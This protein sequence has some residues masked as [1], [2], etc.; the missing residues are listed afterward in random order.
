MP[1]CSRN[2]GSSPGSPGSRT[3][4]CCSARSLPGNSP[5][6]N[7]PRPRRPRTRAA[8]T[9]GPT[10]RIG[11]RSKTR[12]KSR[13]SGAHT[14]PCQHRSKHRS[15]RCSHSPK[16]RPAGA[17]TGDPSPRSAG[18]RCW[19]S[20]PPRPGGSSRGVRC[21]WGSGFPQRSARSA[22]TRHRPVAK[23]LPPASRSRASCHARQASRSPQPR[24]G[25]PSLCQPPPPQQ[26][27][28][29]P[30]L[31]CMQLQLQPRLRRTSTGATWLWR[32]VLRSG[33][34]QNYLS[35]CV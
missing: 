30:R 7:P 33:C 8:Q 3:R 21:P 17:T 20:R 23:P 2:P 6:K 35:M 29:G 32:E 1:G 14:G 9:R 10:P 26:R 11:W 16:V 24:G 12:T 27:K 25:R 15:A 18:P 22:R 34:R 19:R 31:S 28:R 13:S 4:T 5:R